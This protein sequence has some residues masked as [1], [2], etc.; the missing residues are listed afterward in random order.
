VFQTSGQSLVAGFDTK[1]LDL[2]AQGQRVH[3]PVNPQNRFANNVMLLEMPDFAS[4]FLSC[5]AAIGLR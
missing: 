2:L 4:G 3:R 1:R 5:C